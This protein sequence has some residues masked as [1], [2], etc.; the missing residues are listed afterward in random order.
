MEERLN[1]EE[2]YL[3]KCDEVKD[4]RHEIRF[5]GTILRAY[6]PIVESENNNSE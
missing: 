3:D 1:W 6:L 5:L 4:L 2:L